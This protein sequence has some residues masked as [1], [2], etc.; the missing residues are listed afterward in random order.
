[1]GSCPCSY[2]PRGFVSANKTPVSLGMTYTS[3]PVVSAR[4]PSLIFFVLAF[5]LG[6]LFSKPLHTTEVSRHPRWT[7]MG[8]VVIVPRD[9]N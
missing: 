8:E 2:D 4:P 6:M 3:L 9:T 1:M 7:T 5:M